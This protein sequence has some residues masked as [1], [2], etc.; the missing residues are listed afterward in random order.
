MSGDQ[1]EMSP[2]ERFVLSHREVLRSRSDAFRNHSLV[3][4]QG[5]TFVEPFVAPVEMSREEDPAWLLDGKKK[6]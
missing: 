4:A 2:A 6:N 1:D 5:K 3:T